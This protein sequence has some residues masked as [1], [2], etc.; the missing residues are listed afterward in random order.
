[1]LSLRDA[2]F[3]RDVWRDHPSSSTAEEGLT[4]GAGTTM[5]D[6]NL[7]CSIW[8]CWL[9]PIG[10]TSKISLE[11][12]PRN[13]IRGED[14]APTVD[15]R[16]RSSVCSTCDGPEGETRSATKMGEAAQRWRRGAL[17]LARF[18]TCPLD[19]TLYV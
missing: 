7:G 12:S 9:L 2:F 4:K 17:A 18:E 3:L 13:K 16:E 6:L 10:S 8:G 19:A 1:M 11:H 5:M 14:P 15:T